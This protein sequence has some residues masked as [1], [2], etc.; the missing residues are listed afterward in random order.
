[1]PM[2]TLLSYGSKV[3]AAIPSDSCAI[4]P[5]EERTRNLRDVKKKYITAFRAVISY[6]NTHPWPLQGVGVDPQR[7]NVMLAE[8]GRFVLVTLGNNYPLRDASGHAALGCAGVEYYRYDP[9]S[10]SLLP[11]DGCVESHQRF[12]PRLSS[13]PQ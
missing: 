4:F 2:S 9:S 6:R 10:T 13:L 12:L 7:V 5:P 3:E 11:F 8:Y 1:M